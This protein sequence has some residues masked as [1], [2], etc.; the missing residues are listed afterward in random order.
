MQ[1]KPNKSLI[2]QLEWAKIFFDKLGMVRFMKKIKIRLFCVFKCMLIYS[3]VLLFLLQLM[4]LFVCGSIQF[5]VFLS[6]EKNFR[7]TCAILDFC[8]KSNLSHCSGSVLK[9]WYFLLKP[10]LRNYTQAALAPTEG[11][12]KL[13]TALC[14]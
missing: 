5:S 1:K 10:I 9:R 8:S 6:S 11:K 13:A 7:V 14:T 12:V 4:L 3:C 2:N